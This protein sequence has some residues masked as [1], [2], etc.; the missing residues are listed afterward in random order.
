MLLSRVSFRGREV[1]SPRIRGLLALLADDLRTGCSTALLVEGLWP[2]RMPENPTKA[3]QVLVSRARAQLGAEVIVSTPSGY[4]LGVG[5][6][7]VDAAAVLVAVAETAR[8]A[9]AGDHRAALDRAE[10]GIALWDG[11]PVDDAESD[12]PLATL[13]RQRAAT[14]RR[15]AKA[16]GLALAGLGR[17]AE[18]YETLG[19]L[20]RESPRDEE[21]LVELLHAEA[22]TQG[23][24]KALTT[25]DGYR[26]EL[27]D[28]LGTEP[29]VALQAVYRQL[30]QNE[31]PPV[32]HGV[33]HEPNP[34]LGRDEEVAAVVELLRT[35]RVASIVGP[36]GLGKTRL[37]HVVARRTEHR[38]VHFVELARVAADDEVAAEVASAIGAQGAGPMGIPGPVDD[39]GRIA[40][41]LGSGTAL[42][43]LD[44]CEHVTRG[45]AELVRALVSRT[46]D[47]GILT[48]TRTPLGL[49]SESVFQLPELSLPT[50]VKL[51]EQRARAARPDA[52]LARDVVE[53][54]CRRLDGLP[55]AVELAAARIRVMSVA[56][57]ARR[58]ENRFSLLRGGARDAPERHR[59]LQAVVDWSWNLLTPGDQAAMRA[60]SVFPGGFTA[61]A[62]QYLC[63]DDVLD[64]LEH[65]VDQS[66]LKVADQP[67]GARFRMLETVREFSSALREEAGETEAAVGGLL[68]WAGDFGL[69]HHE[70]VFGADLR[71][72]L[73]VIQPEQDNLLSALRH[74]LAR[75]DGAAV[76]AATAVLCSTWTVESN[77]GRVA[78]V[79]EETSWFLSHYR[80]EPGSVDVARAAA[81]FC[82]IHSFFTNPQ[83]ALRHLAT[84][85]RLPPAP[86]DSLARAMAHVFRTV[87]EPRADVAV[88]LF[89]LCES[90]QPLLAGIANGITSY[91]LAG[92][93]ES[94]QALEAAKRMRGAVDAL[95]TPWLGIVVHSRLGELYLEAGRGAEALHHMHTA[96]DATEQLGHWS[97]TVGIRWGMVMGNLQVGDVDEAER[98]L[99]LAAQGRQD[100]SRGVQ[101]FSL[102]VRAEIQ[103]ARGRI[104]EGLA[105]WRRCAG[106]LGN[107]ESRFF[108]LDPIPDPGASEILSVAVAAHARHGRIDAVQDIVRDLPRFLDALLSSPEAASPSSPG[109]IP[110]CGAMLL[111]LG[112]A[113][114]QSEAT[115]RSGAR[116][117]ALAERFRFV[118]GFQPTMRPQTARQDAENADG[119]AYSDAVSEYAGLSRDSLREAALALLS[120]RPS[121]TR[122]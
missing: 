119:P 77:L 28:E 120:V 50:T 22:A 81:T 97:D 47:L 88:R 54:L 53:E 100:E 21:I 84:L 94:E 68:C 106:R 2:D 55:L 25:Y 105:L 66:L 69:R 37:A 75:D 34:L 19:A 109:A 116:M 79:A 29:G 60:L 64:T 90:D 12:D 82:A 5:E 30:L 101:T 31:A 122:T 91:L 7:Q 16:R 15:L 92:Q 96:M 58:L 48:T 23:P 44:N 10:A 9:R 62:A 104:E 113:D 40:E 17:Y 42:L 14:Y 13:R 93:G 76:A 38:I 35:S 57:I 87:I 20:L 89:E 118:C 49:L 110:V 73:D 6:G 61:D 51:F 83:N 86:P 103:L 107:D 3:V 4:R 115:R 78:A 65:L 11:R 114:I 121:R 85:R 26:R 108:R 43:I 72:A 71:G 27:R 18:A 98:W 67:S 74:G 70:E 36:G 46:R 112:M 117:I 24:S 32:R 99:E 63:G 33:V 45:A 39:V 52:V 41:V 95:G 1:T 111:A 59:T 102:G 56:D 80:P 8:A